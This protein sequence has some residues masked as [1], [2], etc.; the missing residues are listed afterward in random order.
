MTLCSKCIKKKIC[1]HYTYMINNPEIEIGKCSEY[2]ENYS[3]SVKQNIVPKQEVDRIAL[4][5]RIEK[6]KESKDKVICKTCSALVE[7]EDMITCE[8]G[9]DVCSNCY[10]IDINLEG[11]N[12]YK[13]NDCYME[14]LEETDIV[15]NE[16]FDLSKYKQLFN[17]DGEDVE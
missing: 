14:D 4:A 17:K 6:L 15:E 9:K 13:C 11:E 8:C 2:M 16:P 1:K 3:I 12:I 7:K 10:S 5:S